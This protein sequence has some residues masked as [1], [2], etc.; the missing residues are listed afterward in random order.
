MELVEDQ[1]ILVLPELQ[2]DIVLEVVGAHRLGLVLELVEVRQV[3]ASQM[4]RVLVLPVA[5]VMC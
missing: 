5:M 2:V 3:V 4:R 1:R